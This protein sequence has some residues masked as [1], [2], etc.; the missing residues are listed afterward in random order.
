LILLDFLLHV[1]A[2]NRGSIVLQHT[3]NYQCARHSASTVANPEIIAPAVAIAA[4]MP[5]GN[6]RLM[7][8]AT[9]IPTKRIV[10]RITASQIAAASAASPSSATSA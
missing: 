8:A 1:T 10:G 2:R 5:F 7:I 3:A 4:D 6:S 9:K